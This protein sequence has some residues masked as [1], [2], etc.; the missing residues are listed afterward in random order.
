M[1]LTVEVIPGYTAEVGK[2]ITVDDLNLGFTPIITVDG[3]VGSADLQDGSIRINHLYSGFLAGAQAAS[4]A[5][6]TDL[7]LLGTSA[8]TA[9]R[10]VT[11]GTLL[12]GM[13]STPLLYQQFS[14]WSADRMIFATEDG[15]TRAIAPSGLASSLIKQAPL[16]SALG[17][18]AANLVAVNQA[19]G[20][21]GM[22][23][24]D[25]AKALVTQASGFLDPEVL[26]SAEE[27]L[28]VDVS[29]GK[30][31]KT[32]I[33]QLLNLATAASRAQSRNIALPTAYN[34]KGGEVAHNFGVRPTIIIG[35]L[36]C[37]Q[38][39]AGYDQGDLIP[40]SV[41]FSSETGGDSAAYMPVA[42]A[43]TIYLL[44]TVQPG[45]TP[46]LPGKTTGAYVNPMIPDKW[47][48]HLLAW[49]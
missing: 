6:S 22:K 43:T 21:V 44:N 10:S 47:Q 3:L 34:T 8:G 25:F 16:A 26:T 28:V 13:W 7:L 23:I 33:G 17:D 20:A 35:S 36:E 24:A 1:A 42:T 46:Y 49:K 14:D 27:L 32:T 29:A 40:I 5:A 30:A 19:S 12:S 41:A 9:N 31:Q 39:D 4:A 11:V 15:E 37:L 48:A 38:A 2:P 45:G 18:Y